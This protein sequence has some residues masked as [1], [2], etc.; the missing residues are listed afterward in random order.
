MLFRVCFVESDVRHDGVD[1]GDNDDD[2]VSETRTP[3]DVFYTR[4]ESDTGN[5]TQGYETRHLQPRGGVSR[6]G[7]LAASS[8]KF[9]RLNIIRKLGRLD[10]PLIVATYSTPGKGKI[11][12]EGVR[13]SSGEWIQLVG[14]VVSGWYRYMLGLK[15][16]CG[17]SCRPPAWRTDW[18]FTCHASAMTIRQP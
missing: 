8:Q 14:G 3:L 1:D 18:L 10:Y 17:K 4:P 11:D 16:A 15:T 6:R 2:A 7:L 5:N 9:C 12:G 13:W